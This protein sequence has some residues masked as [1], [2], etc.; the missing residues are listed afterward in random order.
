MMRAMRL[1]L[2][3]AKNTAD[4]DEQERH[5]EQAQRTPRRRGIPAG[6]P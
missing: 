5:D 4:D 2:V 3:T 1:G 6:S